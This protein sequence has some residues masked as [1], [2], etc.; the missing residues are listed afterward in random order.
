MIKT[1]VK[2]ILFSVFSVAILFTPIL[3]LCNILGT[4]SYTLLMSTLLSILLFFILF[5]FVLPYIFKDY[6]D[7]YWKKQEE[8][9]ND[10][11]R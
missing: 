3:I 5:Y 10:V 11:S 2:I 7:G 4:D 8:K 6:I 9:D 1:L